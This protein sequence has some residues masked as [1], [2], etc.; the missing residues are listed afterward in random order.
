MGLV[1]GL[2]SFAAA[3]LFKIPALPNCPSIFWPT[4]SAALRLYCAELAANKKTVNDLLEAIALVNSL[5]TD[6]PL[7]PEI[8]RNIELWSAQ[9]LELADA[10]FHNGD[11]DTAIQTAQKIP[12][13][14]P[15]HAAVQERVDRWQSIW[16]EAE[17]IYQE[18]E[19]AILNEDLQGAFSTAG[20]LLSVGNRYWETTRYE[21]LIALI[22]ATREEGQILGQARRLARQGGLSQLLE[23]IKLAKKIE[24]DS[25]LY[26]AAQRAVA[27]FGNDLLKLGLAALDR[28]DADLALS[29]AR[30]IPPELNLRNESRDLTELALA[31]QQASYGSVADL[32]SAIIQAQRLGRD[33]PLYDN[34]QQLIR[35]WQLEIQAV[36]RLQLAERLAE[37]GSIDDLRAAIAE[38]QLIPSSNPRIEQAQDSINQWTR[39]IQTLEDRPYL[40]RAEQLAQGGDVFA[41]ESAI[42][43]ARRIGEGRALYDDAQRLIADWTAQSQRIQDRPYLLDARRLATTGNLSEAI[44]TAEQ[45]QPGRVLYDEAQGDINRWQAQIVGTAQLQRAYELATIPTPVSLSSAIRTANQ[46]PDNSPARFEAEQMINI[47]SQDILDVARSVAQDDIVQAIAIAEMVPSGTEAYTAAQAQIEIWREQSSL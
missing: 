40:D 5:P 7:R 22:N 11:F 25:P 20:R 1:M 29:V 38:A 18:A 12:V 34:A 13:S 14:T 24:A 17:R 27:E 10:S 8:D 28:Y 32:E 45:I 16:A 3:L 47:W 4:A 42:L 46:V 37:P 30:Q 39:Q 26:Q 44:A 33:R 35:R 2:G 43:E 19:S 36:S 31:Q 21:E 15:A 23:A 6:H 9:I 41:L